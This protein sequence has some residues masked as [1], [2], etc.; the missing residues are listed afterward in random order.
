MEID[1][2]HTFAPPQRSVYRRALIRAQREGGPPLLG[3]TES[4]RFLK[5]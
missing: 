1:I 3:W 2:T 5:K 4:N